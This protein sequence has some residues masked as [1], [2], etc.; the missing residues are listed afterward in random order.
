MPTLP[1]RCTIEGRDCDELVCDHRTGGNRHKGEETT[2]VSGAFTGP[3]F[4]P[5]RETSSARAQHGGTSSEPVSIATDVKPRDGLFHAR[6]TTTP[7]RPRCYCT[8]TVK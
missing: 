6:V 7:P 3:P 1:L 8:A 2:N 4:A 5:G